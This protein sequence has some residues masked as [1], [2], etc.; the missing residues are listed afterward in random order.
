MIPSDIC[1]YAI[2]FLYEYIFVVWYNINTRSQGDVKINFLIICTIIIEFNS[3][4]LHGQSL[5]H[6]NLFTQTKNHAW[7][8]Q[9][10]WRGWLN[11]LWPRDVIWRHR[12]GSTLVQVMACCLTAPSHYLNQCWLII[13]KVQRHSSE[14]NFTRDTSAVSH[15]N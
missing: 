14:C 7:H 8:T 11:S 12:S 4:I 13:S 6:C 15:W 10:S 2:D 5:T 9:V 1:H 3:P